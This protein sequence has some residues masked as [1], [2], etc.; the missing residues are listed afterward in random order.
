MERVVITC[1]CP[2]CPL[3]EE[4]GAWRLPSS[5]EE[6]IYDG[7]LYAYSS[8][9]GTHLFFQHIVFAMAARIPFI[10]SYLDRGD[11]NPTSYLLC[12]E[13]GFNLHSYSS[14]SGPPLFFY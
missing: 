7:H 2:T 6:R 5:C 13:H 10:I 9:R 12:R 14:S 1:I 8:L 4:L 3:E 11:G